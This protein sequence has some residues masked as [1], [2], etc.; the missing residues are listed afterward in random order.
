MLKTGFAAAVA[1]AALAV[2]APSAHA[3]QPRANECASLTVAATHWQNELQQ[4][5]IRTEG[6]WSPYLMICGSMVLA[7][8]DRANVVGC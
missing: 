5:A 3:V 4:E 7:I 2:G 1:L 8:Q 6:E